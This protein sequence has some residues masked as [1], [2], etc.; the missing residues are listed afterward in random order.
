MFYIKLKACIG[1]F[2][3]FISLLFL[4]E[5]KKW[6]SSCFSSHMNPKYRKTTEE[7]YT[8]SEG[9]KLWNEQCFDS[10]HRN[11]QCFTRYVGDY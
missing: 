7:I 9:D 2:A 8:F 11:I 5:C 3:S 1:I 10:E 6:K 4:S